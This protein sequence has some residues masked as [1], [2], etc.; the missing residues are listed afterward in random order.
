M[1]FLFQSHE[2]HVQQVSFDRIVIMHLLVLFDLTIGFDS[3]TAVGGFL[4]R[5]GLLYDILRTFHSGTLVTRSLCGN[6]GA[7]PRS[8]L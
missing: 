3:H 7:R 2:A 4:D 1:I 8:V 6:R 5:A